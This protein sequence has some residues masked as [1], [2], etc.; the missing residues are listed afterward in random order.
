MS[1]TLVAYFSATGAT[2]RLAKA[3]TSV[4]GADLRRIEPAVAYTAA[5]LDWR[6]EGSR[7]SV[8]MR[9]PAARPGIAGRPL[10]LAG[11]EVVYLGSPIWWGLPPRIVNAF[12]EAHDFAGKT[13]IPFVTS[14]SSG[15]GQTDQ[16]LRASGCDGVNWRPATRLAADASA[17]Q[18][19]RWVESS[20][21]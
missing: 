13:V 1:D 6:D 4:L 21:G 7:S 19:R 14:G 16:R 18:L 12:L 17:N 3:L 10:D 20:T 9:D 8:E 11:Y 2:E 15:V 5:D